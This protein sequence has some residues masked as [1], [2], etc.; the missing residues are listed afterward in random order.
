MADMSKIIDGTI[1]GSADK[2]L[3]LSLFLALGCL[4]NHERT[5]CD[6][7]AFDE[8]DATQELLGDVM[9][10]EVVVWGERYNI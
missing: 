1:E 2:K 3:F 4:S 7:A 5:R 8:F 6:A 9:E 10:R